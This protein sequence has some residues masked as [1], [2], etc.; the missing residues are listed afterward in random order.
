MLKQDYHVHSMLSPD[1]LSEL[2]DICQRG[3][4][5]GLEEITVTDHYEMIEGATPRQSFQKHHLAMTRQAVQDCQARW[6]G[7]IRLGFGIEL[8]QWHQQPKSAEKVLHTNAYDYVLASL[9]RLDHSD[10]SVYDYSAID[11]QAL[12]THYLDELSQ[13]AAI[14]DY[15]CLAHLDLIKRYAAFQGFS[16]R[17]EDCRDAVYSILKTVVERG[18]G[19]EINTSGFCSVL[20]EPLPS[21]EILTWYRQL[22]GEIIT[23]G[24]DAHTLEQ[25]AGG[26]AQAEELLRE[27]GFKYVA[28]FHQRKVSFVNL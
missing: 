21:R 10:L 3:V 25:I 18:K 1:S 19:L 7:R 8:G 16:L 4:E 22:G 2:D 11:R 23:V 24:S 14:G 15:D 13:I 17:M 12:R 20:G 9:H 27:V 26:F 6:E 5:L 28:R